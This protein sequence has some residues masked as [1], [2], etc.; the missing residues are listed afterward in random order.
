MGSNVWRPIAISILTFV[1]GVG[2]SW[3]GQSSSRD[4]VATDLKALKD[5][6]VELKVEQA[7]LSEKVDLL[8]HTARSSN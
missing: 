1:L 7:K 2:A 4:T 8:L 5:E 6:I 3:I